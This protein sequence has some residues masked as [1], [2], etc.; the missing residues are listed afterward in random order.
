M[1]A[2]TNLSGSDRL[3]VCGTGEIEVGKRGEEEEENLVELEE[4]WCGTGSFR[5]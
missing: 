4:E 1:T 3:I 2:L 5:L